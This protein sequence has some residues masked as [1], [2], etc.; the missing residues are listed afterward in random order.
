MKL[1]MMRQ[2]KKTKK[3]QPMRKMMRARLKRKMRTNPRLRKSRRLFGTG[4]L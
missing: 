4:S 2:R 1:R 3:S